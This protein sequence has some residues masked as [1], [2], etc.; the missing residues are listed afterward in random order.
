MYEEIIDNTD[1][2][3]RGFADMIEKILQQNYI[4]VVGAE[5][6][7]RENKNLFDSIKT[8]KNMI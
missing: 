6:H 5:Q 1:E 8:F 2:D 3:I 4:S 7:I